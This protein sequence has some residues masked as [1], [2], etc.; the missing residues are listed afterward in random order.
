MYVT[1]NSEYHFRDRTCVAVRDRRSGEFLEQHLALARCLSGVVRYKPNGV[2]IPVDADPQVGEALYFGSGGQDIVT[3][4]LTAVE[5]PP[6]SAL[7]A[8]LAA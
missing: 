4:S 6:K 3:S 5:R 2:A 1:R 8:Y 7:T